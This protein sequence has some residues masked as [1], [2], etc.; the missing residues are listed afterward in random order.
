[1]Q[2]MKIEHV[3]PLTLKLDPKNANT[4]P[5]KSIDAIK[6]SY[7]RFGQQKPI[8]VDGDMVVR[9]GNGQLISAI[10]LGWK[11]IAIVKTELT[12]DEATAYAITANRSAEFAE[13]DE[14]A[15]AEH[16]VSIQA[17]DK[18][19]AR[20]TGFSEK[21]IAEFLANSVDVV[22]VDIPQTAVEAKTKY[23]QVWKLGRHR[24]MCGDS[25]NET[26]VQNLMSGEVAQMMV[27]DPPYGVNYDPQWRVERG[28]TKNTSSKLGK[29]TN[30]DRADWTKAW[31]LFAGDVA[32]VYHGALHA[33]E[34]SQSLLSCNFEIRA[35]I[36]WNK[37]AMVMGRGDYHWKHEPCLFV[38][39]K[40]KTSNRT[41]DR[42][43]T[44]VW[45]IPNRQANAGHGHSTQKPIE[46][47]AIP[48]RNHHFDLIYDP[49]LGSGTTLL[50]SE[51]LGRRCFGL[52]INPAYCDI[53][54]ARWE[55][56]TGL[57]AEQEVAPSTLD[58]GSPTT[59]ALT[60]A[61]SL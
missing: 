16:L 33:V 21:E 41:D 40:K 10:S 36:I 25:T 8:V 23:G 22:E 52:E 9:D 47:M 2:K 38:V 7:A 20:V 14:T 53:V 19:L 29:V 51:Q 42:T 54:I 30:D 5:T 39:R 55:S 56:L 34:V 43:Q 49:F 28:I 24:L 6:L 35:V 32:Y 58:A 59:P 1:M 61:E 12:G 26:D 11:T 60:G 4:H 57:V 18:E 48:I 45:D 17:S 27:T 13:W 15:L 50:A 46:C 3:D 37:N 31:E 44:T